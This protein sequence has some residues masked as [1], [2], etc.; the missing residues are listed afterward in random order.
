MAR[1]Q[2]CTIERQH[3]FGDGGA[4]PPEWRPVVANYW[5]ELEAKRDRGATIGA[6]QAHTVEYAGTGRYVADIQPQ[7]RVTLDATG[8]VLTVVEALDPDGMR[9]ELEL[10]LLERI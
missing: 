5:I 1:P 10:T 9:A 7:D 6:A 4:N 2:R 3:V 8:R